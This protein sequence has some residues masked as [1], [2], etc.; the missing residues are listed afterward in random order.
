MARK[1][2]DITT[3]MNTVLN[4]LTDIDEETG[5]VVD[6]TAELQA[7]KGEFNDKID[8]CLFKRNELKARI[9]M[10]KE[11]IETLEYMNNVDQN[12]IES[13]DNYIIQQMHFVGETKVDTTLNKLSI[14]KHRSLKVDDEMLVPSEWF[15][16]KETF[17]VDKTAIKDYIAN[18]GTV[19][20]VHIEEKETIR[21]NNGKKGKQSNK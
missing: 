19:S 8:A 16:K 11:R 21:L 2:Y 5:E 1:F 20:G 18:G 4:H 14:T 17:Y 10:R 15:K 6:H 12:A 9:N 13:L 7:L 3:D